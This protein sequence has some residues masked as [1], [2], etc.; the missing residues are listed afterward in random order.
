MT[1]IAC[2][3]R[4]FG[5][6][7]CGLL[8][9]SAVTGAQDPID[10][11]RDIRP[12][13]SENCFHCHGPDVAQR[14]GE[15]ALHEHQLALKAIQ[16]GHRADSSL[17]QRIT[18]ADP[19]IVMPPPDSGR[20]LTPA[21]RELLGRWIDQGAKWGLHWSWEPLQRPPVPQ[22]PA[23]PQAPI[24]NPIDAFLQQR[25]QASGLSPSAEA[26]REVLIRRVTL[27]LTGLPPAPQDV[28]A[29]VQDPAAD[30]WEKVV[31]RL[32]ASPAYGERMAWDWLDAARYAD[33]NGYQGDSDRTM[34]PWR[35][36]VVDAFNRNLPWDQFTTWQLAGDLLP[37]ATDE[38]R[39]ATGFCRNHMINGE[40]GRIAEENRV[41]YVMDMT[42]TMGTLWLGLTLNCCRCHDH[43]FD[44]L[45]QRD[46][47]SLFAIF[48]QTPVNGGGGSGQTAPVLSVPS[49]Q[50][51]TELTAAEASTAEFG[52]L[53][54]ERAAE[55]AVLLPDWIQRQS[56]QGSVWRTLQ[57]TAVRA[58]QQQLTV[59][60]GGVV[61]AGGVNPANDVYEVEGELPEGLL[62]AV[63]LDAL[64]HASHT[65][66]GLA[67]SD[68]GN[69][70][71][72]EIELLLRRGDGQQML[73]ISG[74][75]ATYEQGSLKAA[76]AFDR[77]S[78]TGWAVYEGKPIDRDH[79]AVFRL[80][81]AV[82]VRPGDQLLVR[83]R[84]DSPHVSHNLGRFRISTSAVAGAGLELQRSAEL[85]QALVTAAEQR[86]EAQVKLLREAQQAEDAVWQQL[87]QQRKAAEDRVAAI[88]NSVAKVMV[89]EDQPE[90]R[91][92]FMLQRGLYTNPGAVVQ[93]AVPASLPQ[94]QSQQPLNRLDLARWLM[95]EQNPLTARVTVNRFWQQVFGTGLVKT[96]N[97]FGVQAEVPLHPELLTWLAV[98]FRDSGWDVKRLMRLMVT[99]QA[100]RQSSV[101]TPEQLERDPE[102][103]LLARA[104]RYRLPSWML[105]DQ[106]LAVSGLLSGQRGGP[107]VNVY[108][109]AGVWEEATFGN[110]KYVQDHGEALYRR[111]LYVFWRRIIGPTMFFDTASRQ[112]CTVSAVRTNTPLHALL[113]SN[114][115]AWVEAA[116]VLAERVLLEGG[117]D[118][119][120]LERVYQRV[121]CRPP[122]AAEREILLGTL[123]RSRSG[124]RQDGAAAMA[125]LS[126]GESPRSQQLAADEHAAW[127]AVCLAVLNL[128]EAL[129]K[130]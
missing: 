101:V 97:D 86:S 21:Q 1:A 13:L 58:Q 128:D 64:R 124:Y 47:Y 54:N 68:S 61:F 67:R 105:R 55:L 53:Q 24:R 113:T 40:G 4:L 50:Q 103:R 107:A 10:F 11:N 99:S 14:Q 31:D 90:R 46:Y 75:V 62:S 79:A 74:A 102:N 123:Q 5:I 104:P 30:A 94:V 15:L 65:Q 95:S 34:W 22:P 119:E 92:T 98:E 33:S 41:D 66:G 69:F 130:Q 2:R 59:E 32:L 29:F 17:Y 122:V 8:T 60:A 115:T 36:W 91:E 85:Q 37:Q 82:Q 84:H 111:S 39:L 93:A 117:G 20:Q 38:Q 16:P 51:R 45:T 71:L 63:R 56:G 109:P 43:K 49:A 27:D 44:T 25:L 126:V 12:L 114:D 108:Q 72:T 120:R 78:Q 26:A 110:R 6:F 77:D 48:N 96:A 7:V 81:E 3:I 127:T 87:T 125:L 76:N 70:V 18:A 121:L 28:A 112:T 19:E 116:R 118:A 129:T 23:L 42:E 106:A 100:Y 73:R 88:R 80:A 83:L 57:P 9:V 52:R 35:D 89:M